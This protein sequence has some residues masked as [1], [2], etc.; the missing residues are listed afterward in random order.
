MK[1]IEK[2]QI[3]LH[4]RVYLKRHPRVEELKLKLKKP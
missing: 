3:V 2:M 1:E 4:P